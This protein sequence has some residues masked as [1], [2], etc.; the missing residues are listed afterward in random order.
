MLRIATDKV[1]YVVV[2]ARELDV[3]VA[4]SD[5]DDAVGPAEDDVERILEDYADD[6]TL[7]ELQ[8]FLESL[9]DEEVEDLV[10]LTWVGRGDFGAEEWEDVLAE[11]QDVREKHSVQYLIG[12]PL[13]GDFL[14]EGLAQ[15]GL[16][17]TDV[18]IDHL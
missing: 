12:T 4:P 18:E 11:I 13:L 10:A 9:N 2:K 6:P 7:L 14:E 15:F 8:S 1:C 3:K 17:C 16:S 5:M